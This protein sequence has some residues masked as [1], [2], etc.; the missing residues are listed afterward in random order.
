MFY[1]TQQISNQEFLGIN[2]RYN[3]LRYYN[4]CKI[5]YNLLT[6]KIN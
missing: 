2:K 3:K 1:L 6:Q 4:K 5:E